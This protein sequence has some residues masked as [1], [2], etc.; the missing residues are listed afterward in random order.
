MVRRLVL[1]DRRNAVIEACA[2]DVGDG[3]AV[4]IK[5]VGG[6]RI[7]IDCGSQQGPN[8]TLTEAIERISPNIFVLSHFHADHYNGLLF[9]RGLPSPLAPVR[10]VFFPRIPRFSDRDQFIRCL[11]AV[12]ERILGGVSGSMEMDFLNLLSRVSEFSFTY[13]ALSAGDT[14]GF[15]GSLFHVLWPPRTISYVAT[16][17]VIRRAIEDFNAAI[18]EDRDLRIIYE[19][20]EDR[21]A[22]QV[23][24]GEQEE[25]HHYQPR[26]GMR[27]VTARPPLKDLPL[28]TIRAIKSLRAAANHFS[29][30]FRED[31]RLLFLGDLENH[32]L[33]Q[34]TTTLDTEGI[35]RFN[36]LITPHHGTHWHSSL[37]KLEC[38]TALSTVGPRL[39]RRLRAEYKEIAEQWFVTHLTGDIRIPVADP[40][41]YPPWRFQRWLSRF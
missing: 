5:T 35:H 1:F 21:E 14:F 28:T 39:F 29:L 33:N 31:N 27:A 16:L 15:S 19:G 17:K 24:S 18:E 8:D 2:C 22:R 6:Q 9:D 32:E 10:S 36:L 34:V 26:R 30:A 12:N 41:A 23:Y 4:G 7:Q 40:W 25:D 20:M 38:F 11:F 37:S 13:R 3:M